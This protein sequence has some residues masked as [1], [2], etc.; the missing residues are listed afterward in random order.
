MTKNLTMGVDFGTSS[1]RALVLDCESGEE[2]STGSSNYE[3]WEQG[4]FCDAV[5]SVFRHHPEDLI[6]AFVAAVSSAVSMLPGPD[7]SCIRALTI[8]TTGSS[9]TAV[10]SK[11]VPLAL[12]T[13]FQNEPDG[14]V[15]LWKDRSAA[16]EAREI[17]DIALDYGKHRLLLY[18]GGQYSPEWYWAKVLRVLRNNSQVAEAAAG[19]LEHSD[20]FPAMLCDAGDVRAVKRNRCAAAHKALWHAEWNGFP[21][22]GFFAAIDPRLAALRNSLPEDTYTADTLAGRLTDNWA[23][24]TGLAAGTPVGVGLFDAHAAAIGAGIRPGVVSKVIGTSSAEM[25]VATRRAL[26]RSAL[27]GVESVADGSI[28]PGMVGIEAGQPAYGDLLG[29]F[30]GVIAAE[31]QE[32]TGNTQITKDDITTMLSTRAA[33]RQ[34]GLSDPVVL[35]WINGRRAPFSNGAARSALGPLSLGIDAPSIF[36]ALVQGAAFGT[37]AIHDYL[38]SQGL[39]FSETRLVGGIPKKSPYVVQTLADVLNSPAGVCSTAHA[40]ARGAA[41]MAAVSGG[42]FADTLAAIDALGSPVE[43]TY[44]PD[45]ARAPVMQALYRRYLDLGFATDPTFEQNMGQVL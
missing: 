36:A 37:R 33:Q 26:R 24:E 4:L 1:V 31:I 22:S 3:R 39:T 6:H 40:S 12:Q 23:R 35:D 25:F 13:D 9:P 42:L 34:P 32:F 16:E 38:Q 17:T 44:Q 15:I 8:D 28:V 41:I 19:W 18:C 27:E 21:P 7:R 10:D 20:W 29:W 2:V 5:T 45:A 43:K 30:S 11:G 14:M